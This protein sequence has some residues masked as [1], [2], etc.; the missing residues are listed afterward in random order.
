MNQSEEI[1]RAIVDQAVVGFVKADPAGRITFANDRYC[2][3]MGYSR[4]E[5][6]G[7]SWQEL[8]HPDD[9][10]GNLEYNERVRGNERLRPFEKRNLRKNG[11]T[12]WVSLGVSTLSNAGGEIL[13]TAAFVVDITERMLSETENIRAK[14]ELE[15]TLAAIPDLVFELGLDGR[16]LNVHASHPELLAAPAEV[17]LGKTVREI[18]PSDAADVVMSA[19]HEAHETGR[20]YGRQ[21]KLQ[22]PQGTSW[23]EFSIARK[24]V[25]AGQEPSFIALVHDITERKRDGELLRKSSEEI[26]GLYNHAPCG[27]QSLDKDGII[28][29]IND[30]ELAWLGYT[31]HEVI[32]KMKVKDLLTPASQQTFVENFPRLKK[33]GF[34][35]NLEFEMIRKDGTVFPVLLNSTAIYDGSGEYVMSRSTLFD[36]TERKQ[37]EAKLRRSEENLNRAQAVG[38]IGSWILDIPSNKLEWSAETY[39]MFGIS[40]QRTVDLAIFIAAIHPDDRDFVMNAWGEAVADDTPYKVEHRIVTGGQT[41]WVRERAHI[42]RDPEGRP[43]TGIGTVQDITERKIL[44]K[45]V[46]ER[47]NEMAELQKLHVAAQTAAAFAHELNQP[48]LAIASYSEAALMLLQAENPDLAKARKA[49][50]GSERQAHR[51][52]QSIRE[53]L[54]FLSMKEF[55]TEAFDLNKEIIATLDVARLEYELQFH[56]VLRLENALPMIRA[57]RTHIQ[58]VLLNLLHNSVE[59][60][61][62]A[63]LLPL[64]ITVT[65]CTKKEENL[66]QM[67]IQDNGPG[68]KKT[69]LQHLFE[70][71]F[72]TKARGIGMGL[73]IS[74]SLIEA[75]GG[76]LWVNPQEGPGATFHITLPIAT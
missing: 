61:Q 20:S 34:V 69:D 7:K 24:S 29:R 21:M 15:A 40:P 54:E 4:E 12:V 23:F 49:I 30:T 17:L 3:I 31:R 62:E 51:A 53:L 56:S 43:L 58:K 5:L 55:P 38:Q 14:C 59:A 16:Y 57:N 65:I 64:S 67:T 45:E 63:G 47:R 9:L 42:E 8:T 50:E 25:T 1:F 13:G 19:L 35:S 39:R 66:V 52:G 48:L 28:I 76:Q 73:A 68:F 27:Y 6:L 2:E 75:N 46:L 10:P 22:V 36:N 33:Q 70:P 44:E 11:D 26:E 74:R 37:I 60:M 72:T 41:R 18:L 71:F 32:G